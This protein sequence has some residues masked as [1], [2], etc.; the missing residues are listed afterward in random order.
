MFFKSGLP[1]V[2]K[3][4]SVQTQNPSRIRKEQ[5]L[6]N[7]CISYFYITVTKILERTS[8]TKNLFCSVSE[9]SIHNGGQGVVEH[10]SSHHGRHDGEKRNESG[11]RNHK[12]PAPSDLHF[13]LG[14]TL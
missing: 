11:T 5:Q 4:F 9:V 6:V 2:F 12:T 1:Y 7:S 14:S 8:G 3:M 10:R 13:Q